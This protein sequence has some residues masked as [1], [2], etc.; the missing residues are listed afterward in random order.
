MQTDNKH[1]LSIISWNVENF[2]INKDTL[3]KAAQY[4]NK[5]N[6]DIICLQERPHNNLLHQDSI[7]AVFPEHPYFCTNKREDEVLNI[8]ILSKYPLSNVQTYYFDPGYN[9]MI[10]AEVAH[11]TDTITLFNIHLQTTGTITQ[12]IEN[13]RRRN[14]QADTLRKIIDGLKTHPTIISGDFNDTPASYAYRTISHTMNDCYIVAN[15][16]ITGSYQPFG[17]IFRIDYTL[18]S[19]EL[20]PVD[21]QLLRNQWSDH[22]IQYATIAIEESN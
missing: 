13:A 14:R 4:I 21:Y 12:F 7:R 3:K 6:P 17:N 22:K 10:K 1:R 9:K 18:C 2:H 20:Y 8:A 15:K 11:P 19:K 16:N 5:F